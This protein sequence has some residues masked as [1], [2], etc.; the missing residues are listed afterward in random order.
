LKTVRTD[1]DSPVWYQDVRNA[2]DAA[3]A[4][5][6][7]LQTPKDAQDGFIDIYFNRKL[8][9][10]LTPLFL[11][12]GWSPNAITIL[13]IAVGFAAAGFFARGTYAAGVIGALLFQLAAVIDCC[14]GD[15]A[16]LTFSESPLGAWLDLIG[17]NVVHMA[18]FAGIACAG[19]LQTASSLPL[20]LGAAAIAGNGLSLWMVTRLKRRG[21]PRAWMDSRQAARAD[22]M[23]RNVVSRDFSVAVLLFALFG[24]LQWFLWLAAVGSHLFWMTMAWLSRSRS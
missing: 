3:H 18:I 1:P 23:I 9:G 4:E 5:R 6:R 8:S 16:R 21:E 20:L 10:V 7:L 22:F 12:A 13:S 24:A 2:E 17:D 15:V 19:Y 14:D 11:K